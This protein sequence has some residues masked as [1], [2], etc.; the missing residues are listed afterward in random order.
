MKNRNTLEKSGFLFCHIWM[1]VIWWVWYKNLW[2][3]CLKGCTLKTSMAALITMVVVIAAAGF[4]LNFKKRRNYVSVFF[5]VASGFGIYTVIVYSLFR[6][7]LILIV[8]IIAAVLIA[9]YVAL[10]FSGR[11]KDQ[12]RYKAILRNRERQAV[13][14]STRI[15]SVALAAI[16][17]VIGGGTLLTGTIIKPTVEPAGPASVEEQTIDNN[18]ETLALLN[19]DQWEEVSTEKKVDVL[20]TVA[21]I[22]R[23]YLGLHHEL[24]IKV[25]NTE[26]NLAGYYSDTLHTITISSDYLLRA[27]P[28]EL[29]NTVCHESYHALQYRMV[30]AY[31]S[32]PDELKDLL[33]FAEASVLK[34]E[35]ADYKDSS[36]DIQE[37]YSQL[38]ETKAR[39]YARSST[40]EYFERINKYLGIEEP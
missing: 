35:F 4:L 12:S 27:S 14:G 9:C 1:A 32:V 3:R 18:I 40:D 13:C 10:V 34:A 24:N 23:R 6:G 25:A 17:F 16:M 28:R 30:D 26:E 20:Q 22:E 7:R 33:F 2:F 31:D 21:N 38:C 11:I 5:D 19:D 15:L 37:Y 36:G 39:S 8:G 29:V